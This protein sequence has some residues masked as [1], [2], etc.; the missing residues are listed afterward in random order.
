M[1]EGD[2]PRRYIPG[3]A[4]TP[5]EVME[6]QPIVPA[7]S[8][9]ASGQPTSPALAKIRANE[10]FP[11]L[12]V[13]KTFVGGDRV[14]II[15]DR[16][17]DAR[18]RLVRGDLEVLV[19]DG[20]SHISADDPIKL[21]TPDMCFVLE[22]LDAEYLFTLDPKHIIS[23]ADNADDVRSLKGK[24]FTL[25]GGNYLT[26]DKES[27]ATFEIRDPNNLQQVEGTIDLALS[28]LVATN[29]GELL[30]RLWSQYE[31]DSG[32]KIE[33]DFIDKAYEVIDRLTEEGEAFSIEVACGGILRIINVISRA[34]D[35]VVI[36]DNSITVYREDFEIEELTFSTPI[37]EIKLKK[38]RN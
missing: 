37:E 15:P 10:L 2:R 31:I 18:Q 17:L 3:R 21:L 26:M 23:Y 16:T 6:A 38:I 25:I 29:K 32:E 8:C 27:K 28:S 14:I 11:G 12:G 34:G 7:A 24:I 13:V 5:A 22:D 20:R 35:R 4:K 36:K 19:L 33:K 30:T 1:E 9:V